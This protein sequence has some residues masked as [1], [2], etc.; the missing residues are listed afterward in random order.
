M[1]SNIFPNQPSDSLLY[2]EYENRYDDRDDRVC[3]SEF[4][5]EVMIVLLV[6]VVSKPP[7]YMLISPAWNLTGG[8]LTGG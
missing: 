6:P 4:L 3:E 7:A 2:F 5:V 1:L 8:S